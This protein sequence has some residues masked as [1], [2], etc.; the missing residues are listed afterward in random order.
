MAVRRGRWC[1]GGWAVSAITFNRCV[2]DPVQFCSDWAKPLNLSE[3]GLAFERLARAIEEKLVEPGLAIVPGE[4]LQRLSD[5][6][7]SAWFGALANFLGA[8]VAQNI[9]GEILVDVVDRT[10]GDA[11]VRA[12]QTNERM[13]LHSD[14]SDIAGLLCISSATVGGDSLFAS[15]RTVHDAISAARPDLMQEFFLPWRW[16]G[17][18]LGLPG[19]A[20]QLNTPIFSFEP[21][22]R[23]C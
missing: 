17:T 6:E 11:P 16:N 22:G 7:L 21:G 20:A 10:Q 15:A 8:S 3:C 2:C 13:L 12:Y 18:N 5:D 23:S 14:A 4:A 1:S 9:S 19:E